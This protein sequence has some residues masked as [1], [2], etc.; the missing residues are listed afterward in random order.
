[1]ECASSTTINCTIKTIVEREDDQ[2]GLVG[3]D[4]NTCA[5]TD[6]DEEELDFEDSFL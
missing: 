1:M 4:I 5:A 6:L 3:V 2:C